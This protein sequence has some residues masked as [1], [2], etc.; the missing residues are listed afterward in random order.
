MEKRFTLVFDDEI[1]K[2][3]EKAAKDNN[4]KILIQKLLD[5]LESLGPL[6]GKL[7]DV[8]FW[9]YELKNKHP[10]LRIYFKHKRETDEIY[11]L[12]YEMKTSEEKQKLTID[13]LRRRLKS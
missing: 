6:A 12:E 13:R 10:P 2:Q 1:L 5:R 8:H 9:L 7:L 3:L 11:V 4:I